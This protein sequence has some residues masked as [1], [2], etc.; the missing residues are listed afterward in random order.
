[1]PMLYQTILKKLRILYCNISIFINGV[2][3]RNILNLIIL[4]TTDVM[5][6]NQ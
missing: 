3:E 2:G 5:N 1:M 6:K 4:L